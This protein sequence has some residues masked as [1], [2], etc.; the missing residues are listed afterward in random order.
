[1]E[2]HLTISSEAEFD[3]LLTSALERQ[4]QR[5]REEVAAR[6][7]QQARLAAVERETANDS[8]ETRGANNRSAEPEW[9]EGE[10]S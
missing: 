1:M 2:H 6:E 5:L 4:C 9:C 10:N 7:A 3:Q 8:S